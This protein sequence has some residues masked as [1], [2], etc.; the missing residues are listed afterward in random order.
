[1]FNRYYLIQ[2]LF[3]PPLL[4]PDISNRIAVLEPRFYT[5]DHLIPGGVLRRKLADC[6]RFTS[7]YWNVDLRKLVEIRGGKHF[8]FADGQTVLPAL[9]IKPGDYGMTE[10]VA[11][12]PFDPGAVRFIDVDIANAEPSAVARDDVLVLSF[13]RE[14][15]PPKGLDNWAQANYDLSK[16]LQTVRFPV[17]QKL[18][19][20]LHD[21]MSKFGIFLRDKPNLRVLSARLNDGRALVPMLSASEST[22]R[23]CNDGAY[24]PL[25]FPLKFQYDVS[26]IPGAVSCFCELS[27]PRAMF[28]LE[29]FTY[30]D[31]EPSKKP[32]KQWTAGGT[33]GSIKLEKN[34]F[35][36]DACYQLRIFAQKADGSL[37]GV[38]S[39][40]I[41]LGINDRPK[42][43]PL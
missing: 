25:E 15:E 12:R 11:E 18:V 34:L 37:C 40:I 22:L 32:L 31:V 28:Q 20:F 4:N 21:D 35:A 23:E 17:D 10:I 36:D 14:R 6:A 7:V 38:S 24:R 29:H 33:A 27:R 9:K 19:W 30:R 41:D 1:M 2:S 26:K 43:Q 8:A 3:S 39:D 42:W 5:Y 13:D 16:E